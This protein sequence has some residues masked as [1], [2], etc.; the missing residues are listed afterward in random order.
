MVLKTAYQSFEIQKLTVSVWFATIG[1]LE[2]DVAEKA[3]IRLIQ[4]CHFVPTPADIIREAAWIMNPESEID[5]ATAWGVTMKAIQRFGSYRESEGLDSLPGSVKQVVK[6]FGWR[7]L[8]LS[9]NIDVARGEFLKMFAS[10]RQRET[11]QNALPPIDAKMKHLIAG[12]G[13]IDAK[14]THLTEGI[15]GVSRG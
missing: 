13:R 5:G 6:C 4:T 10:F 2:F 3:T 14:V 9:K 8:C 12:I 11:K 7:E 15:E 1:H